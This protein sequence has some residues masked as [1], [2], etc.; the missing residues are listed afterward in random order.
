[1]SLA[2]LL[3][4][5]AQLPGVGVRA[6]EPLARH[7]PLRVGG[8]AALWILVEDAEALQAV[9]RVARAEK[10]RW[11]LLWPLEDC[12][13]RDAGFD[14]LVIRPGA[15]FEGAGRRTPGRVWIRPA[16]PWA[17]LTPLTLLTLTRWPGTVGGLFATQQQDR[18]AGLGMTL[19]ILKGGREQELRV[20]PD[21][22]PPALKPTEILTELELD[23]EMPKRR[24]L[25]PPPSPGHIFEEPK[26]TDV[27]ELLLR[28]N[29]CGSRLRDWQFTLSLP[30]AIVHTGSGGERDAMLLAR[31]VVERVQRARG[32]EL[33]LRI[34]VFG[35]RT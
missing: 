29:V 20:E 31:G 28:A 9:L 19:R 16:T 21:Q 4:Q 23:E 6:Q 27:G 3:P 10:A 30:G 35:E 25:R 7:T 5:L 14:G 1:M 12:I 26:G 17:A 22:D 18:L 11:R 8:P 15:G 34:P 2:E 33:K 24:R 32:I 13:V